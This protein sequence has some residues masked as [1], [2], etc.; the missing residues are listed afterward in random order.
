MSYSREKF[1]WTDA[2]R[3]ML[4]K[5]VKRRPTIWSSNS[6][7]FN[8]MSDQ[9]AYQITKKLHEASAGIC[10]LTGKIIYEIWKIHINFSF[11]SFLL[12]FC[13]FSIPLSPIN[14]FFLVILLHNNRSGKKHTWFEIL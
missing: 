5:E 10:E 13:L 3:L 8:N 6:N 1:L 12:F 7:N 2:L 4:I 9:V 14:I 11:W